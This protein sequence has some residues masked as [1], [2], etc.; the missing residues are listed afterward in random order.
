[1]YDWNTR[2]YVKITWDML[3]KYLWLV[4]LMR[5]EIYSHIVKLTQRRICCLQKSLQ[6]LFPCKI[7]KMNLEIISWN[8]K[9][10]LTYIYVWYIYLLKIYRTI[11]FHETTNGWCV[12]SNWAILSL[13]ENIV[14]IHIRRNI[15]FQTISLNSILMSEEF[16]F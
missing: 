10:I 1:M 12:L 9:M 3:V 15:N 6:I 16:L 13:T 4:L 11:D 14:K 2:A 7:I 8:H 5:S